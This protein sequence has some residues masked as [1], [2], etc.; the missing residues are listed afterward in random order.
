MSLAI[1]SFA[2]NA[3]PIAPARKAAPPAKAAASDERVAAQLAAAKK[4]AED[5]RTA[6]QDARSA[7]KAQARE[8]AEQLRKEMRLL[9]KLLAGNP[10]ELARQIARIA[11][12]MRG[13][14]KQFS[15]VHKADVADAT[16]ARESAKAEAQSAGAKSAEAGKVNDAPV[17]KP[18]A[19][20]RVEPPTLAERQRAAGL[21][22]T[23]EAAEMK[24]FIRELRGMVKKLRDL[25]QEAKIKAGTALK[26]PREANEKKDPFELAEEELK[27]LEKELTDAHQDASAEAKVFDGPGGIVSLQA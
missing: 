16:M 3:A 23:V 13:L 15:D 5:F 22:E 25:L 2:F 18:A 17:E 21:E 19:P 10:K 12:E 1:N 26:D 11:K 27:Q 4:V 9:E 14:L 8:R 6:R 7:M 24:D 20:V